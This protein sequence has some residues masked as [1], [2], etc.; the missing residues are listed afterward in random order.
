MRQQTGQDTAASKDG[1]GD[2]LLMDGDDGKKFD[3][4]SELGRRRGAGTIGGEDRRGGQGGDGDGDG[5]GSNGR[6]G[7]NS[8]VSARF[9]Y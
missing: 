7:R 1:G 3:R 5:D 6:L 8:K 4:S 9:D 2:G